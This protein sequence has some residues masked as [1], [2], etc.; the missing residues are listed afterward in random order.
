MSKFLNHQF[1][2]EDDLTCKDLCNYRTAY[3][4]A[5]LRGILSQAE[6]LPTIQKRF[7]YSPPFDEQPNCLK[8]FGTKFF[9]VQAS[10]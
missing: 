2:D 3:A 9:A 4:Q 1:I 5:S 8:S 10:V 6:S 7:G